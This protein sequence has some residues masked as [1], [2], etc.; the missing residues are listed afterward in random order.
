M[1][2]YDRD[3]ILSH[4]LDVAITSMVRML[5][6]LD[7]PSLLQLYDFFEDE[8]SVYI[9]IEHVQGETLTEYISRTSEHR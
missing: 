8:R 5:S 6:L 9:V 4:H 1:P 3:W 2:Q 7:H